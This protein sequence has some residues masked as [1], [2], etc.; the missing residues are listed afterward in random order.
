MVRLTKFQSLNITR[1]MCRFFFV[2]PLLI[3]AIDAVG[4]W[5]VILTNPFASDML[6]IVAGFGCV[7]SSMITLMIFF[8]RSYE[9][10]AGYRYRERPMTELWSDDDEKTQL[11]GRVNGDYDQTMAHRGGVVSQIDMQ[12]GNP[13]A[14]RLR[15][16]S[17]FFE[18]SPNNNLT[19]EFGGDVPITPQRSSDPW[20]QPYIPP[21]PTALYGPPPPR[22]EKSIA[23]RSRTPVWEMVSTDQD[24][25]QEYC[26]GSSGSAIARGGPSTGVANLS[27][28]RSSKSNLHPILQNFSSPINVFDVQRNPIME[29]GI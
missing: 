11:P 13:Y 24:A 27:P 25:S 12:E 18:N 28:R 7:T 22:P 16:D 20:D 15:H 6:A 17:T 29:G 4:N 10:E 5:D 14:Y 8:P 19:A 1:V 26:V 9:H 2:V 3:M 23:R 21:G